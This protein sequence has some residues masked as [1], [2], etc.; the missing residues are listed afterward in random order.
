MSNGS[1][2]KN[3]R[4]AW[5][6]QELG[7]G[8]STGRLAER[9]LKKYP[10]MSHEQAKKDI[11]QVLERFTEVEDYT[12]GQARSKYLEIMFNVGREARE[13]LQFGPAVNAYK[14]AAQIA[15]VLTTGPSVQVQ[16]VS[17]NAVVA[18]GVPDAALVRARI[19]ALLA[20]SEVKAKAAAAG[21]DVQRLARGELPDAV[22]V[23]A[24]E[25]SEDD[26]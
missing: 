7:E 25:S 3:V 2:T 20:D 6:A 19:Q 4:L 21:V 9:Y 10:K 1:P 24:H 22:Q 12:I 14:V 11:K 8:E 23:Q 16:T 18:V 26:A 13:A 5:I 15:G 17:Q